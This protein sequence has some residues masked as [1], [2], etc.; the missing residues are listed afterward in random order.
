MGSLALVFILSAVAGLV[1]YA[2][3]DSSVAREQRARQ[4]RVY[5]VD[6][7][8]R[9]STARWPPTTRARGSGHR[10]AAERSQRLRRRGLR[11]RRTAA[12]G[13][14]PVSAD[15]GRRRAT[16]SSTTIACCSRVREIQVGE[17]AVGPPA[18]GAVH[19]THRLGAL[20]RRA[21]PGDDHGRGAA[22][23][24]PAGA[25]AFL[26]RHDVGS[27]AHVR[28][29]PPDGANREGTP[30]EDWCPSARTSSSAA[31]SNIAWWSKAPRPFRS[32]SMSRTGTSNTSARRA[33][34]AWDSAKSSGSR[35]ASSTGSCRASAT[36][37]CAHASTR[38]QSGNFELETTVLT[39]DESASTCAGSRAASRATTPASTRCC[40][41]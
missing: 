14:R 18:A 5:A 34:S 39:Q 4:G 3:F 1:G 27:R 28:R 15:A 25:G 12:R 9:S 8:P 23:R 37:R 7:R 38:A 20:P 35:S 10:A 33:R 11:R 26:Q 41:A 36:A 32:R 13:S 31:A 16:R 19:R 17:G 30:R 29:A 40:A 6:A 22:V 21:V 2:T 24:H